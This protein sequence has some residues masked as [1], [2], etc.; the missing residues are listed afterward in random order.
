MYN[1]KSKKVIIVGGSSGMGL[2]VAQLA[3]ES[4]AD[5]IVVSFLTV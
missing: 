3:F 1:L 4:V 2:A 5:V